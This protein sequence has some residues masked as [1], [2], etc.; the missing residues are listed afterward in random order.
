MAFT[1]QSVRGQSGARWYHPRMKDPLIILI[2][3]LVIVLV[4]RGPKTLPQ[5]GHMLGRGV[6]EARREA[7][8]IKTDMRK[9]ETAAVV[10]A[11]TAPPVDPVAA[12]TAPPVDP[13]AAPTAPPVD[14]VAAPASPSGPGAPG[15]GASG[16]A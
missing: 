1:S 12:P 14:P 15:P 4:W 13:V 9:D 3:I 8:E 11:P 7:A 6:K 16:P 5:I 2:V 10:A